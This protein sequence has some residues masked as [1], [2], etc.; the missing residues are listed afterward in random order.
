VERSSEATVPA[1]WPLP[2]HLAARVAPTNLRRGPLVDEPRLYILGEQQDAEAGVAAPPL[3]GGA[4]PLFGVGRRHADVD[5][6][7]A[8]PSRPRPLEDGL[9]Q[10]RTRRQPLECSRG[11]GCEGTVRFPTPGQPYDRRDVAQQ[12]R[13]L[14]DAFAG[15]GWEV[16]TRLAA[17][18]FFFDSLSQIHTRQLWQRR[19]V[20]L[21]DA[22]YCPLPLRDRAP[23][24]ALVEAYALAGELAGVGG[25]HET[26]FGR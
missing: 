13:I 19:T 17:P 7:P 4:E 24:M 23:S 5:D 9:L 25:E 18:A 21:G 11:R 3:D 12:R 20:L 1:F 26:A 16:P 2:I 10:G 22:G 14:A 6:G 8:Q 15:R